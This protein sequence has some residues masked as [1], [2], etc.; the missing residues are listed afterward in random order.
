MEMGRCL[1]QRSKAGVEVGLW[2]IQRTAFTSQGQGR[3]GLGGLRGED[4]QLTSDVMEKSQS[5]RCTGKSALCP[6]Q[7]KKKKCFTEIFW[8]IELEMRA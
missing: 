3:A 8:R 2:W 1:I 6:G 4:K 5:K 7:A